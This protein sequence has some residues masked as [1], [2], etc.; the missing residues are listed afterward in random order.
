MS[1]LYGY[2]RGDAVQDV[3]RRG[4]KWIES[5]LQTSFV[6]TRTQMDD[7]GE[8]TILVYKCNGNDNQGELLTGITID[9]EG[10][11]SVHSDHTNP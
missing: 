5:I 7:N 11:V 2:L 8:T 9:K 6:R 3:T 4:S 10:T 1:K